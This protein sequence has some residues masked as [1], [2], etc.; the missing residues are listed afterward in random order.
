MRLIHNIAYNYEI[1]RQQKFFAQAHAGSNVTQGRNT[2]WSNRFEQKVPGQLADKPNRGQPTRGLVNLRSPCLFS[3]CSQV[4]L[5]ANW[6]PVI[7]FVRELTSKRAN[8]VF[9]LSIYIYIYTFTRSVKQMRVFNLSLTSDKCLIRV[10]H[11]NTS[12]LLWHRCWSAWLIMRTI[13]SCI[14]NYIRLPGHAHIHTIGFDQS[15][16][17]TRSLD[18]WH[19]QLNFE[20]MRVHS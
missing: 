7:W 1:R 14:V 5:S 3:R 6:L 13:C 15:S 19:W 20:L 9:S 16:R 17:N 10:C 8:L 18:L 4:D 12:L 11:R 2:R